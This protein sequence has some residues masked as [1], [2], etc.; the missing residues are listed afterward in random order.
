MT[1]FV[2]LALMTLGMLVLAALVI[3]LS[4]RFNTLERETRDLLRKLQDAQ[5]RPT[6]PYAG[7]SGKA[8]WDAVSGL[9]TGSLDEL[10]LDGIRKRYRLLLAD[11]VHWIFQEGVG[12]VAKG[13]DK[14]PNN[15]RT[16]RTPKAQVESWLPPEAVTEIY[17]C[18]QGY[19]VGGPQALPALRERLD[20]VCLQLHMQCAL[21]PGQPASQLLMPF[22]PQAASAGEATAASSVTPPA[23][24]APPGAK[25]APSLPAKR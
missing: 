17:R 11:H 3:Y 15:S 16:L 21:E 14:V 5:A 24:L 1:T 4:D 13:Y 7:L 10:T 23:A 20:A 9:E 18:G 25:S 22:P 6:G 2:L 19:A 12:D 8:L